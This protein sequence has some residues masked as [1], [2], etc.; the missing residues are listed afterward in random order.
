M[1]NIVHS[2]NNFYSP[3]K[4]FAKISEQFETIMNSGLVDTV[5]TCLGEYSAA[6]I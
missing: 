4:D 1:V 3:A 2:M 5:T 6:L